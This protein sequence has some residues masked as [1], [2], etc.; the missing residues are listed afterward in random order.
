MSTPS[1]FGLSV[2]HAADGGRNTNDSL[3]G[4]RDL[5]VSHGRSSFEERRCP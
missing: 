4:L 1:L 5:R 2:L 3:D